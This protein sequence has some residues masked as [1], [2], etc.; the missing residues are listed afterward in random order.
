MSITETQLANTWEMISQ[1][2][3]DQLERT[4]GVFKK[5]RSALGAEMS[6]NF[7]VGD[8]VKFGRVQGM[9]HIGTIQKLNIKKAVVKTEKYGMSYS[10][11]YS[12]LTMCTIQ[13]TSAV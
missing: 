6:T 1:M 10:V 13:S 12:M 4:I 3:S 8:R 11:P 9:K 7:K 2:D 5:R